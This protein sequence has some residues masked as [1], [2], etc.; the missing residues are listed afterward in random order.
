VGSDQQVKKQRLRKKREIA[1][2]NGFYNKG[3]NDLDFINKIIQ[4]N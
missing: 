2:A 3:I 4:S 1:Q